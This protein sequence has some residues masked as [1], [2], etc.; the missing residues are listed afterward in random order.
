M[1]W[2]RR[3]TGS[4][5]IVETLM[6]AVD[7]WSGFDGAHFVPLAA[8][9]CLG[10]FVQSAAGLGAGLLIV[11]LLL[12]AGYELP[13]AMAAMLVATVPQNLWGVWSFREQIHWPNMFIPAFVRV[14][15]IPLGI[16]S[17]RGLNEVSPIAL[18]QIVGAV[19]LSATLAMVAFRVTPRQRLPMVWSIIAFPLSGFMQGMVGMGGPALVLWVHAHDWSTRRSR[20]FL[21]SMYTIAMGPAL[22]GLYISFGQT[23]L[24]GCVAAVLAVP[25]LWPAT[26]LG[27]SL[28]SWLGRHRLRKVTVGLLIAVGVAGLL[29]PWIRPVAG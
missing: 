6:A 15:F 26:S 18:R 20:G 24:P 11:P 7:W 19:V 17:L 21:F 9:L 2:R 1:V 16:L 22:A 14:I 29:A 4:S 8:V 23:I 5:L 25:L 13:S 3:K 27:L 10:V 12:W 28:G